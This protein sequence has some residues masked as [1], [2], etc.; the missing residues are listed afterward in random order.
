MHAM[1]FIE[2][3]RKT[4]PQRRKLHYKGRPYNRFVNSF[5]REIESL[6]KGNT[7]HKQSR[8][9]KLTPFIHEGDGLLRVRGRIQQAPLA[10]D[11]QHPMVTPD[12]LGG[13]NDYI[14]HSIRMKYWYHIL[15][16]ERQSRSP[17]DDRVVGN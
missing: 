12:W 9:K 14:L 15:P 11:T 6:A 1:E 10:Y 4:I 3:T 7:I 13:P 8:L 17:G 2:S 16:C 5:P